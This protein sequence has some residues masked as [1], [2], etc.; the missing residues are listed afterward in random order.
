MRIFTHTRQIE[1]KI[2]QGDILIILG[3]WLYASFIGAPF[4]HSEGYVSGIAWLIGIYIAG[5]QN[6]RYLHPQ[7]RVFLSVLFASLFVFVCAF[8][9]SAAG[10][11]WYHHGLAGTWNNWYIHGGAL[12]L[13]VIATIGLLFHL[14]ISFC[15]RKPIIQ[16]I[17]YNIPDEYNQ[18]LDELSQREDIIIEE[19]IYNIQDSLP[20]RRSE[21]AV[22]VI[23]MDMRMNNLEFDRISSLIF[24][25]ELI[26]IN[27]L[28]ELLEEKIP[29]LK[30]D[31]NWVMPRGLQLPTPNWEFFKRIGDIIFVVITSP[32]VIPLL[33]LSAIVIKFTS[34]GPI[35]Y[36]QMRMGMAGQ[37]FAIY[38]LRT[39]RVDAESEG[40]QWSGE[41]DPRITSVGK[42]LRMTAIDELPQFWNVFTG[43]MSLVGPRP[44]RPEIIECLSQSVPFYKV[45]LLVPPGL[46]GWAQL[47]QGGDVGIDDVINKLKYDI[48]YIKHSS[49]LLDG[50]IVLGTMQM[51]LHIAK[52]RPKKNVDMPSN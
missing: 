50:Q 43:Q 9:W 35:F 30:N 14:V 48:Y 31:N 23:A 45:R 19:Q 3:W 47:H 49:F 36:K 28:Y 17:P 12:S 15:Y 11:N 8:I 39:M 16:V 7:W 34:K 29:I 13:L 22:Y 18:L 46:S 38:K 6:P 20:L 2:R 41:T 44:E 24:A 21:C 37:L 10:G 5:G 51:M 26:D 1:T 33:L 32:V 42:F 27:E 25:E 4:M 40:I 52:P